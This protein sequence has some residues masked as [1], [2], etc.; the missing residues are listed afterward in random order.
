MFRRAATWS[1]VVVVVVLTALVTT[2]AMAATCTWSG[3]LAAACS[4]FGHGIIAALHLA[5]GR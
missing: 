3:W 4:S 2:V 5:A 1:F